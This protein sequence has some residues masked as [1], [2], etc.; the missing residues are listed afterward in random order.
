MYNLIKKIIIK[1]KVMIT[2]YINFNHFI[3]CIGYMCLFRRANPSIDYTKVDRVM[4]IAHPDDEI[5]SMGNFLLKYPENLLVICMTNGGNLKRLKEFTSL[6]KYLN[7]QYQIW[8]FKD[9]LDGKWNQ[10]KV[11]KKIKQV[12]DQKKDWEMVLTH[13]KDGDYGHF[14]HKEVYRL[15]RLSYSKSNLFTPV[16][17]ELLRSSEY[18]LSLEETESKIKLFQ[19]Y[20]P[21]QQHII[22]LYEEYFEYEFINRDEVK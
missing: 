15:V 10:R 2:L 12:I 4:F 17:R 22:D 21:S 19:K 13:N 3:Y 18:K 9:S 6:M 8:N 20:Y 14:Q 5:V 11:L 1:N 7:V 16:R